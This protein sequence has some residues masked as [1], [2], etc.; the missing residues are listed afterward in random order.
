M[1]AG[2]LNLQD[3]IM[4]ESKLSLEDGGGQDSANGQ[5]TI[6]TIDEE[7]HR[8]SS[9]IQYIEPVFN[10]ISHRKKHDDAFLSY[11]E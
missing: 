10:K 4:Q 7:H 1:F 6:K 3:S 5:V 8:G 9:D 2:Q 11:A